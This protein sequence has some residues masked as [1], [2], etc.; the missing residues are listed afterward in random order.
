MQDGGRTALL[1][2]RPAGRIRVRE[3]RPPPSKKRPGEGET[4]A[5]GPRM[6]SE[7]DQIHAI[8]LLAAHESAIADLYRVYAAKLPGYRQFF[9]QLAS[10]EV[11]H[12]RQI[13]S[14]AAKVRAGSTHINPGR[15][16]A[17]SVLSS[18]D[19]VRAKVKEAQTTGISL[20]D[21]LSTGAAIENMML[22]RRFFEVVERDGPELQR[23]MTGLAAA[24]AAHR[25]R[26]MQALEKERAAASGSQ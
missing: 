5:Q 8:G 26:L 24:T 17:E 22:E 14:F 21:A 23:M 1:P 6:S 3:S 4:I 15:F 25:R 16:S 18:I 11:E 9:E 19:L 10:D 2:G 20:I 7:V 12:A 13:I